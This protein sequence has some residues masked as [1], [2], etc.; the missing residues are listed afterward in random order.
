LLHRDLRNLL[1]PASSYRAIFGVG[2]SAILVK[3]NDDQAAV[4]LLAFDLNQAERLH[5]SKSCCTR[6]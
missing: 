5:V 4:N 6:L 2:R 1:W 3:E